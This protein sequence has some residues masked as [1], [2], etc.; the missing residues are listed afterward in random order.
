MQQTSVVR[1]LVGVTINLS[2]AFYI[3]EK[4]VEILKK[5][6]EERCGS[7]DNT[8]EEF[9]E[10]LTL[11]QTQIESGCRSVKVIQ[12]QFE[13]IINLVIDQTHVSLRMGN[14]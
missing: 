13:N 3:H 4:V 11:H 14:N 1:R 6:I 2:E 7:G 10:R 5:R 9:I 12:K 8:H